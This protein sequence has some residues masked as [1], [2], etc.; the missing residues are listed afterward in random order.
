M[1]NAKPTRTNIVYRD[2]IKDSIVLAWIY[3]MTLIM[4]VDLAALTSYH[5]SL[6]S[7]IVLILLFKLPV[8]NSQC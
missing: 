2:A 3:R 1:G 5:E 7:V 8:L 6:Y 4:R